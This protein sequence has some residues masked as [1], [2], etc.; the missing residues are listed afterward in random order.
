MTARFNVQASGAGVARA[1]T[2]PQVARAD[3]V[4]MTWQPHGNAGRSCPLVLE[5]GSSWK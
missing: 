4:S 1:I 2:G 5:P 3:P